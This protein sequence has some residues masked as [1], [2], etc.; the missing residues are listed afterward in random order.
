MFASYYAAPFEPPTPSSAIHIIWNV[1]LTDKLTPLT[2]ALI[3]EN[4]VAHIVAILPTED[5]YKALNKEI[6]DVPYSV[7][8]Y[9][10][11][12]MPV[13]SRE[14]YDPMCDLIDSIARRENSE[15]SK[16]NVLIFCNNGYQRSLPFLAYYL[17]KCH[18]DEVPNVERA[19]D[20]ILPQVNRKDYAK[21]RDQTIRDLLK[22]GLATSP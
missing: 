6:P 18:P 3:E 14:A 17:T 13:F 19:V 11:S 15:S 5:D 7:I 12:H 8:A 4:K 20:L 1:L 21:D 2:Q 10:D 9:G 16:R 22:L